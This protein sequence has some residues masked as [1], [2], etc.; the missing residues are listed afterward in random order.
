MK[1][2]V[3]QESCGG[4]AYFLSVPFQIWRR[5]QVEGKERR[6]T[7]ALTQTVRPAVAATKSNLAPLPPSPRTRR[8]K[9]LPPH[10]MFL[11]KSPALAKRVA[12]V[13]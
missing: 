10:P 9:S 11:P 3:V 4:E 2:P 1:G 13:W 8:R 6:E 5:P 12:R 7:P